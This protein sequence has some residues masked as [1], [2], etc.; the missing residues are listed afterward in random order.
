MTTRF[1]NR[2][3]IDVADKNSSGND[4]A[5]ACGITS[6]RKRRE[7]GGVRQIVKFFVVV[8]ERVQ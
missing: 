6:K 8:V 3:I 2:K 7:R 4:V 5:K 1:N